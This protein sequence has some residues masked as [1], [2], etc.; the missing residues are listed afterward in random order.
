MRRNTTINNNYLRFTP[1]DGPGES[2]GTNRFI[3]RDSI[4]SG[5]RDQMLSRAT[6]NSTSEIKNVYMMP[7]QVW[8][9]APISRYNPIWVK[10]P[11]TN[12]HTMVD[13]EDGTIPMA[14]PPGTIYVKL[15]HIPT[16]GNNGRDFLNIYAT[17]QVSCEIEWEYEENYTKNW[18]PERM[19]DGNKMR[20]DVYKIN[21]QGVYNLPQDYYE[22]MPTRW[23]REKVL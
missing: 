9:S 20:A 7:N 10:T 23:G 6:G 5:T 12:R 17:G 11:R 1:G 16:P 21:E 4:L 22:T 13:T 8:D 19:I 18:R 15:A 3:T 2:T 14:H